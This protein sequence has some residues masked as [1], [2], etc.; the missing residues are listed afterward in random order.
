MLTN[1]HVNTQAQES[2]TRY[3]SSSI[4]KAKTPKSKRDPLETGISG[5][6]TILRGEEKTALLERRKLKSSVN[7][8]LGELPH[9]NVR[10]SEL[11]GNAPR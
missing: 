2:T 4:G 7:T 11:A 10:N 5:N 3:Y 6:N 9:N 8:L 1:R